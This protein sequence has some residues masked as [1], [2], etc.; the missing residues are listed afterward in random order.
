MIAARWLPV[1]G[2]LMSLLTRHSAWRLLRWPVLAGALGV[3]LYCQLYFWR[4]IPAEPGF[5]IFWQPDNQLQVAAV[6]PGGPATFLQPGDIIRQIDGRT[7]R[8]TRPVFQPPLQSSYTLTVERGGVGSLTFE[9][10]PTHSGALTWPITTFLSLVGWGSGA[11]IWLWGRRP[12]ANA[13]ALGFIFIF[14]STLLTAIQGSIW[15]VPG[16]WLIGHV[17]TPLAGVAFVAMGLLPRQQPLSRLAR[18]TLAGLTTAASVLAVA[19]AFEAGVLFP[20]GASWQATTGFSLI[21]LGYLWLA[22]G[23]LAGLLILC[24]RTLRLPASYERRQLTILLFF[25]ALGTLPA[26]FLTILPQLLWNWMLLPRLVSFGLMLFIPAGYF[27]VLYRQGYWRWE[28][29][30]GRIL[31]LTLILLAAYTTFETLLTVLRAR[32]DTLTSMHIAMPFMAVLLLAVAT[33]NPIQRFIEHLFYGRPDLTPAETDNLFTRLADQP[34]LRTLRS[35]MAELA[36]R[37]T[38]ERFVLVMWHPGRGPQIVAARDVSANA[39]AADL[40]LGKL[41]QTLT[42]PSDHPLFSHAPWAELILP[43][44]LAGRPT[45]AWFLARPQSQPHFNQRQI[46]TLRQLADIIGMVGRT[47]FLFEAT[48][49]SAVAVLYLRE[50]ERQRVASEIHDQPLQ[51]ILHVMQQLKEPDVRTNPQIISGVLGH[52]QAVSDELRRIC[53]ELF[54]PP[55]NDGIEIIAREILHHMSQKAPHLA[56]HLQL[57]GL[58]ETD[59]AEAPDD[60]VLAVYHIL[61]ESLNNVIKHAKATQAIVSITYNAHQVLLSV[62]DNG[63]GV[64]L[65][66]PLSELAWQSKHLGMADMYRW[67]KAVQGELT[68]S[69]SAGGGL[70]VQAQLPCKI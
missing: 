2:W 22:L 23:L 63:R 36:D 8:Q 31:T 47:I 39:W 24:G 42:A 3:I 28:P 46:Q 53:V 30:F 61:L 21:R 15:G 56:L 70:I 38:V 49:D 29:V 1:D 54:P 67:A 51:T 62:A 12:E 34:E 27:F 14:I 45:G 6:E 5:V 50:M 57:H 4:A 16:V 68:L 18:R 20:R 9:L 33:R 35:V 25:V 55:L 37:F 41:T 10:T 17:T 19:G 60:V 58:D 66:M 26:V 52:L 43:V 65:P 11:L 13:L 69:R 48:Q 7:L 40:Y 64:K 59:P 44:I 32:V